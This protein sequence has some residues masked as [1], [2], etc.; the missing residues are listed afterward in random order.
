MPK[1]PLVQLNPWAHL[2]A[3]TDAR[4][5]LGRA[6]NSQTTDA[7]LAFGVAHAQARDAV[8]LPLD[9]AAVATA[10]GEAG[11][12]AVTA[13]SAAAAMGRLAERQNRITKTN[14]RT[15][16]NNFFIL[17]SFGFVVNNSIHDLL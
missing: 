15:R 6:G 3:F 10:L 2:R 16:C 1:R 4:I 8:H 12:T 11:F 14:G 17:Y 13:H 9:S 5:A 7:V